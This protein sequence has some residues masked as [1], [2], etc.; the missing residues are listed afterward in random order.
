MVASSQI[1]PL[2]GCK[3][4]IFYDIIYLLIKKNNKI[5]IFV[6]YK[7]YQLHKNKTMKTWKL[8]SA[9]FIAMFILSSCGGDK[10][11][12]PESLLIDNSN[13]SFGAEGG[14]VSIN[15]TSNVYW[16][17]TSGV[18]DWIKFSPSVGM[19]TKSVTIIA[20]EN[21][22]K[23]RMVELQVM[24]VSQ[25][26]VK[27]IT[28]KQDGVTAPKY[29]SL[30]DV[31]NMYKGTDYT[32]TS[33]VLVKASVI[34][35]Y[36]S[37][38]NGGLNNYTSK[39][40]IV[41]SDGTCGIQLYCSEDN[42][43]FALGDEVEINL[44]NQKLSVY[45]NG[46]LQVN[47]LPLAN[48]TKIGTNKLAPKEI[49]AAQ[50]MT[51]DYESMYVAIKEVQI[52]AA[53]MGK[54]FAT[55]SSHTSINFV[56]KTGETFVIFSSKYSS[57]LET[58]V[59]TGSGV[60]KGISTKFGETMQIS[61]TSL[62]DYAGLTGARFSVSGG[63]AQTKT[64]SE[65]RALYKGTDKKI[66]DNIEI[67]GTIIS[68][69]READNGGLNNSTSLKTIVISDGEAGLQLY[70]SSN[71]TEF[72]KGDKVRIN[73]KDQTLSVY[74]DGALQIN[75]L[76]LDNISKIGTSTITPKE[77]TA[78][79]LLTGKYES[80]YVA[81]KDVEV[82]DDDLDKT[83]ASSDEHRS[84]GVISKTGETFEI[85][86]SKYSSYRDE[87][88][89]QGSGT[90][91]GIAGKFGTKYQISF[92][93]KEDYA[94]LT[95]ARF[96]TGPRFSLEFETIEVGGDAGEF[97]VNLASNVEWNAT[98]SD[99]GVT[100]SQ[101][102]GNASKVLTIKYNDNPSSTA[103][104]TITITFTTDDASVTN[105]TL[106]LVITQEPYQLLVSDAVLP[107]LELPEV[108]EK[109][110]FAYI[111]HDTELNG[112]TVRNYSMWFDS[113]NRYA[114]WVAY[115]L[116]TAIMGSGSRT[117]AWNYDPKVPERCQ[118]ELFKSFGVSG[119]DRGHQLPSADRL[120]SDATN[121]STFYFTN[122]TAQNSSLNQN[123]WGNL[124]GKI[125]SWVSSV[126]TLYVVTGA[127]AQTKED[128]T[129]N[130][131]KDNKGRDV[132]IPKAYFKVILKYD[133]NSTV[134]SGYSAIG[135]WFENKSYSYSYINAT[136][137]TNVKSVKDIED[138]TGLD[139]FH[140]LDD[141]IETVV[142]SSYDASS[143]GF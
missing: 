55:S 98:S 20:E 140:N 30:S 121:E 47:G 84:I 101:N 80:V 118:A 43:K 42:T 111:S 89:P 26:N 60:L 36:M 106:K 119:Y 129:I 70:C 12:E 54:T 13:I 33:D 59:P 37:V 34:S 114:N 48:I 49:T 29:T 46:P 142:E 109:E 102:S 52:A 69:Y 94:G 78:A 65:V 85:F 73:L 9:I 141:K 63:D 19:G 38:E 1:F 56:A 122:M 104:R 79:E 40:A 130:Y 5:I 2:L 67:E 110:G 66:T 117:D 53:D 112:K 27:T 95:G 41:V 18:A 143:W 44:K 131:L 51:G 35:N 39:K 107:W 128:A 58:K 133:K 50:F 45:N 68:N 17:I 91:K 14:T 97:E 62:E 93:S 3:Y 75:G 125:R 137:T 134:N 71:N 64:I 99:A 115:P 105:K 8:L 90:L 92:T 31:R 10:V 61:I 6:N 136:N 57:F 116:Y 123:I 135:F 108:K 24:T 7:N 16:T 23:E 15:I 4:S 126:D 139:F 127:V 100:L 28:I 124:E 96:Y 120:C 103:K 21:T 86:S 74:Q 88:V 113:N 82:I 22:G 132:A 81:V 11:E 76:P 138:L 77:I 25:K 72:A 87:K 83:F 32:I